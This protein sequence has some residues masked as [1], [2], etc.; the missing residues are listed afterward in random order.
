MSPLEQIQQAFL[1]LSWAIKL[2][3]YLRIHPP[4]KKLDFDNPLLITDPNDT[5]HLPGNQFDSI[6]DIYLGA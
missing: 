5:V 4:A 1:Q 6:N 3:S 2:T